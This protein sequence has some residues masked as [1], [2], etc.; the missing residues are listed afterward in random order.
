M[1]VTETTAFNL[2]IG[3]ICEEAF[4]RAGLELRTGYDLRTARRSLDLL[5]IE[6]QNR[7]LNLWT[8]TKGTKVLTQGTSQ[9]TLGS[10]V[11]D[12]I[13][14]TIRTDDGDADRQ[15]DIPI[16]RISNSTYSTLPSKLT[17]GRPI[18]LWIDRQRDAPILNFWPVPDGADTYTFV[19]YYLRR[20][21]DVGDSASYN[22]DVPIRF[23]PALIAGLAFH[24][25]MKKPELADR[26]VLL[27]DYYIE[28][29][30]LAAQE[31]RVKAS[32]QFVPYS[33]SYGE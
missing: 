26:V 8:I 10:D 12:L 21:Y 13:E 14:Y 28:Q 6:W 31:D 20:L 32:F 24:I 27:R 18:Q 11:V 25:A 5:C 29:F 33:Y 16:T 7:G 9:Y 22:A 3:E 30:D 19:Y 1:A 2:D 23:L 4:E 17:Q 15:N